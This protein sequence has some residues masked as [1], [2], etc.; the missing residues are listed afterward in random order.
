MA[1]KA[2]RRPAAKKPAPP[3]PPP[4]VEEEVEDDERQTLILEDEKYFVDELSEDAQDIVKLL[5]HLNPQAEEAKKQY[6]VLE[7]ARAGLIED[8][9]IEVLGEE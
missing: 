8:L 3:P 2:T 5:Q 6:L 9:R 1:T 4:P 7:K